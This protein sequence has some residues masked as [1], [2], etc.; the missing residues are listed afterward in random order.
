[1]LLSILIRLPYLLLGRTI[2]K[3][4]DRLEDTLCPF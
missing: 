2:S 1:M 3:F 4:L